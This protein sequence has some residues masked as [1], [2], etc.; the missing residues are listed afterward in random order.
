MRFHLLRNPL[1][2]DRYIRHN[3]NM[4]LYAQKLRD[5]NGGGG[6]KVAVRLYW[7]DSSARFSAHLG[8]RGIACDFY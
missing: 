1:F 3:K 6:S 8:L 5:S 7:R 4:A 2:K